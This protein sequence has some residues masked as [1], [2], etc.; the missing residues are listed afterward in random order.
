M[1]KSLIHEFCGR[2]PAEQARLNLVKAR[3][4]TTVLKYANY[5]REQLLELLHRHEEDNVHDFQR[6]LR[7][8]IHKEVA[9]KNPKT[10]HEAVQAALRAEAAETK[11]ETTQRSTCRLNVIEEAV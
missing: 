9:L 11:I 2:T 1:E 7:P 4:K 10:L 5:F 6:G 8:S 3:Q